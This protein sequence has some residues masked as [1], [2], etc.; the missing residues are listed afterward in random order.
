MAQSFSLKVVFSEETLKQIS[1]VGRYVVIQKDMEDETQTSGGDVK[2][3]V[4]WFTFKPAQNSFISWKNEY[5][6]YMSSVALREGAVIQPNAIKEAEAGWQIYNYEKTGVFQGE[7]LK[8]GD[9]LKYYIKN[10]S[11]GPG[12]F[13]LAQAYVLNG[14]EQPKAPV[15]AVT[16]FNNETADFITREKIKIFL[17]S[18]PQ[19][20]KV[21]RSVMSEPAE[22]DFT[23]IHERAVEYKLDRGK[24]VSID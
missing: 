19:D 1:G 12:T 10:V 8:G 16:L 15:N 18:D 14:T 2:G 4:T 11:E 23:D 7:D 22:F 5:S 13:G 24:F 17:S 3:E 6:V 20:G 21:L 9:K